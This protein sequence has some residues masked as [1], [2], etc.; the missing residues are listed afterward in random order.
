MT[1]NAAKRE[2]RA[3]EA[4]DSFSST[5][6]ALERIADLRRR[7]L[8]EEPDYLELKNSL[9]ARMKLLLAPQD[10]AKRKS[11]DKTPEADQTNSIKKLTGPCSIQLRPVNTLAPMTNETLQLIFLIKIKMSR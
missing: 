8:I 11:E 10:T 7:N 5:A 2:V 3:E 1:A 9:V 6:A 4:G